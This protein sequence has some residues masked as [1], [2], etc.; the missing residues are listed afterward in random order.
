MLRN[1]LGNWEKLTVRKLASD[2]ASHYYE[3]ESSV[4][5]GV[6]AIV[7]LNRMP[8][9]ETTDQVPLVQPEEAEKPS[10]NESLGTGI[11]EEETGNASSDTNESSVSEQLQ[12]LNEN[13]DSA[14]NFYVITGILVVFAFGGALSI[15]YVKS[16][17]KKF[18]Q[19]SQK[20]FKTRRK[21]L[22]SKDTAGLSFDLFE[23]PYGLERD[24]QDMHEETSGHAYVRRKRRNS[25]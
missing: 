23:D 2:P 8:D 4:L 17:E 5:L 3:A 18:S 14:R 13:Q 1:N 7:L 25:R 19:A 12:E 24:F 16:R 15:V 21:E 11:S 10:D 22:E 20:I 9:D 6:Y